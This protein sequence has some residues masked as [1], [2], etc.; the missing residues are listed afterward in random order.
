MK[1]NF[2]LQEE[3]DEHG[4]GKWERNDDE[5]SIKQHYENEKMTL[6]LTN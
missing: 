1:N 6:T 5:W 2:W 3:Q 4:Q